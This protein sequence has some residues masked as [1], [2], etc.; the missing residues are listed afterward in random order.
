MSTDEIYSEELEI[1]SVQESFR[2][3]LLGALKDRER[4]RKLLYSPPFSTLGFT[5]PASLLA[6]TDERWLVILEEE[7][8]PHVAYAT[9]DDTLLLELSIILLNGQLKLDYVKEG[10]SLAVAVHFDVVS[11][12]NYFEAVE[13]LLAGMEARPVRTSEKKIDP[14][15]DIENWPLKFRNIAAEYLPRG[16]RLGSAV[17]W[18][19]I[20]GG[21]DRE[22]APAGALISTE[23]ELVI[24]A[25]EKAPMR[26]SREESHDKYGEIIT[27]FPLR[28]LAD[29]RIIEQDQFDILSLEVHAR[30]GGEQLKL[31]FPPKQRESVKALMNR[32]LGDEN[33]A[34]SSTE[35]IGERRNQ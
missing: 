25:E 4:T 12:G 13:S 28:C 33:K 9:F 8:E 5:A 27:Y 29:C 20:Y 35:I 30:H 6:I 14:D 23:R 21:F 16:G 15:Q 18:E 26:Q 3:A 31:I 11:K 19:T 2:T 32:C 17:C 34:V 1:A 24:V 10:T 7:S 22:I